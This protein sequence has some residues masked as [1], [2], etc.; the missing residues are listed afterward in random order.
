MARVVRGP[1]AG[2]DAGRSRSRR[3][4]D[5]RVLLLFG[6]AVAAA[7]APAA[8]EIRCEGCHAGGPRLVFDRRTGRTRDIAV[9]LRARARSDHAR[10]ACRDCHV[11]R[12]DLFPHPP[13]RRDTRRCSGC[14]PRNDVPEAAAYATIR[15]EVGASAHG[16]LSGFVCESC[17]DPHAFRRIRGTDPPAAIRTMHDAPCISCHGAA[18]TGP[19]ADPVRPDLVTAHRGIVH[20]RLHLAVNR[21][22]DCHDA[23]PQRPVSHLLPAATAPPVACTACHGEPSLLATRFLRLRPRPAA[24]LVTGAPLLEIGHPTGAVRLWPADL[25]AGSAALLLLLLFARQAVATGRAPHPVAAPVRPLPGAMLRL[26]HAATAFAGILLL[27][28]GLALHAGLDG[29][30]PLGFAVQEKLHRVAGLAFAAVGIVAFGAFAAARRDRLWFAPVAGPGAMAE[31]RAY[32]GALLRGRPLP[33]SRPVAGRFGRLQARTYG[34]V[35]L[36][37]LPGLVLTGLALLVPERL[38]GPVAGL[39][40]RSLPAFAHHLLALVFGLFL[41]VHLLLVHATRRRPET[42]ARR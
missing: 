42:S 28:S 29:P 14:H 6:F 23:Q 22:I 32:G 12:F 30:G 33:S 21:C 10:I 40:G 18:A 24:A 39:P 27:A 17:H 36:V 37:L 8:A 1:G 34:F 9:D 7:A 3:R 35:V 26:W 41:L 38:H 25:L 4:P 31:L 5:F 2:P 19:L 16:R 15:E 13:G 20:P 11:G